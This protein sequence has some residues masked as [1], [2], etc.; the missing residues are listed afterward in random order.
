MSKRSRSNSRSNSRTRKNNNENQRFEKEITV[1][2]FEM[3]LMV[4]L[5][6]WKTYSFSTNKATYELY[7]TLNDHMD[8]FIETMLGENG[9]RMNLTNTKYVSLTDLNS[10]Q[11]LKKKVDK[12][13]RYLTNIDS[14]GSDLLNIRDEILGDMNKFLYLLTL[15]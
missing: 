5:F 14:L 11:A 3:L 6:H 9:D 8:K 15:E 10:K 13:K 12:F 7:G 2:F 4:K 1:I